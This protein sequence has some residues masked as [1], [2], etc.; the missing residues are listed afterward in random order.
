MSREST[1][2][3]MTVYWLGSRYTIVSKNSEGVLLKQNFSIGITLR[4]EIPYT[5]ISLEL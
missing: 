1:E 4:S 2:I 5:D 3:G